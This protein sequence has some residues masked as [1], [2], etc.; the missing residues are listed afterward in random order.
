MSNY[1]SNIKDISTLIFLHF[2]HHVCCILLLRAVP[3]Y[4]LL[5]TAERVNKVL[6]S[7]SGGFKKGYRQKK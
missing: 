5:L 1:R 6:P 2:Y 3:S 7:F 4:V